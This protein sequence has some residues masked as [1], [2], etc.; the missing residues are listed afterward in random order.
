MA[1]GLLDLELQ[2]A[3]WVLGT[4]SALTHEPSIQPPM[5]GWEHV[6]SLY[7]QQ[8]LYPFECGVIR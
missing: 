5:L 6:V 1:L 4:A 2:V 3:T 7:L 8:L